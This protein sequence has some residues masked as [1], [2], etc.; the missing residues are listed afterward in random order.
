MGAKNVI[1]FETSE[2][3][4]DEAGRIFPEPGPGI[5]IEEETA[6]FAR[7]NE[8]VGTEIKMKGRLG[9]RDDGG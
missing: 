4:E 2:I 5:G 6:G 1:N 7:W 8:P 3:V 9:H